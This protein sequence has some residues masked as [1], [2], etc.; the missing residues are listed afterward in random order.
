LLDSIAQGIV[1]NQVSFAATLVLLT[2]ALLGCAQHV[3][4]TA[5]TAARPTNSSDLNTFGDSKDEA[6]EDAE[7]ARS[8]SFDTNSD[9]QADASQAGTGA[10]APR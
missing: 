5:P 6:A 7:R 3:N 8:H 2:G 4:S 9:R 1:M 10:P